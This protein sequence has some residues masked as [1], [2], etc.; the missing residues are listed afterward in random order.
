ML[1]QPTAKASGPGRVGHIGETLLGPT[2]LA[3][4]TEEQKQRFLPGIRSGEE[5]WCQGYSEPN[6][7][8]DLANVQT[9]A[10]LEGDIPTPL[11]KPSGCG[12]RT[13]CPLAVDS[14]AQSIPPLV[15]MQPAG[16][17]LGEA[18]YRAGGLPAVMYELLKAGKLAPEAMTVN[19]RTVGDNY[20]ETKAKDREV[21]RAYLGDDDA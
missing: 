17:F 12:F 14:C 18:Y 1:P 7:G 21:I 19:G 11:A 16:R 4:G 8:S 13:R 9:R 20:A 15:D 6:A 5:L 2:I 3:F 10:R